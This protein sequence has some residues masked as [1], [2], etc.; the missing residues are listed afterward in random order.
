MIQHLNDSKSDCK[1][2]FLS[3][4]SP[5]APEVLLHRTSC[6]ECWLQAHWK[7]IF[8]V[9]LETIHYVFHSALSV[10]SV[11]KGLNSW[12]IHHNKSSKNV[13]FPFS[14]A[15]MSSNTPMPLCLHC[16]TSSQSSMLLQT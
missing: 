4:G 3:L 12:K 10:L 1:T 11:N 2:V 6:E 5:N 15:R 14:V 7:Q 16:S 9:L 13:G 8:I